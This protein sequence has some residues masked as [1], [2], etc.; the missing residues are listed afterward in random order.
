MLLTVRMY[1]L[2]VGSILKDTLVIVREYFSQYHHLGI[3]SKCRL[4][5]E[6]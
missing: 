4:W 5:F 3:C 6:K 2:A 1:A